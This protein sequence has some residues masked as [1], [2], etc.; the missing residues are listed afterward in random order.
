[1]EKILDWN[2]GS[3]VFLEDEDLEMIERIVEAEGINVSEESDSKY[4]N[5]ITNEGAAF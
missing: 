4:Q 1:L 5:E 2:H 3:P